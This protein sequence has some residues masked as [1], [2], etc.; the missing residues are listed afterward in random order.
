MECSCPPLE[1]LSNQLTCFWEAHLLL[2]SSLVSGKLTCFWEAHL[3]L[4]SSLVSGKLTSFWE[5]H[6]FL[7]SSL[8]SW[9]LTCFWE[10]PRPALILKLCTNCQS[11]QVKYLFF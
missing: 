7:G 4:G 5:A 1:S 2:G 9:K 6:L 8:V 11:Y 10:E 3:F